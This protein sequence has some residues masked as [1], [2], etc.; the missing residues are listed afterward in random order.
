MVGGNK[1]LYEKHLRLL[2]DLAVPSGVMFFEGVGAGHFAKMVHNG[3]EYGMMQ[4]L[5][6]GFHV[7]HDEQFKI[8]LKKQLRY[9][10]MVA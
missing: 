9:I 2:H 4:A 6:E 7:L 10:I 5:A 8:D 3:I 1:E